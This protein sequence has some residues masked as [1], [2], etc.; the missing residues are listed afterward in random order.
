MWVGLLC[1]GPAGATPP[2]QTELTLET[3]R[4]L[5]DDPG[6][7]DCK[8]LGPGD[9]TVRASSS[10]APESRYGTAKLLDGDLKTAWCEGAPDDGVGAWFELTLEPR[11]QLDTLT[12]HAGYLKSTSTLFNNARPA[13]FR[14]TT[15]AGHNLLISL[16]EFPEGYVDEP[17]WVYPTAQMGNKT[18]GTLRVEVLEVYPGR[19]AKDLCFSG[20]LLAAVVE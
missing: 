18:V 3:F 14:V 9:V 10:L 8:N 17:G 11:R 5:S 19:T 12:L 20:I 2:P 16:P 13:K 4:S 1:S 6:C 7:P 15:D